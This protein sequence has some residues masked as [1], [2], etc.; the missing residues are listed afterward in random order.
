MEGRECLSTL[1]HRRHSAPA[2]GR[3]RSI[4]SPLLELPWASFKRAKRLNSIKS[5]LADIK[6]AMDVL[7]YLLRMY[8][9]FKVHCDTCTPAHLGAGSCGRTCALFRKGSDRGLV[10]H[11]DDFWACDAAKIK[12]QYE[13]VGEEMLKAGRDASKRKI[14]GW[15]K[16][17]EEVKRWSE[18]RLECRENRGWPEV[19]VKETPGMDLDFTFDEASGRDNS[20]IEDVAPDDIV[21]ILGDLSI[22]EGTYK[23]VACFAKDDASSIHQAC[24]V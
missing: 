17:V 24:R 5:T 9:A 19:E 11:I 7:E 16:M 18:N 22:E 21:S 14:K 12:R 15:E 13:R 2:E 23:V 1:I 4:F 6:P 20:T 10:D 3:R 8:Y